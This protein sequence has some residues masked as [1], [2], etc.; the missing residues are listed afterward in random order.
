MNWKYGIVKT[1]LEDGSDWYYLAEVYGRGRHSN[2]EYL[3][4]ISGETQDC[5]VDVIQVIYEDLQENL[6]V[7]D[8]IRS[9]EDE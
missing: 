4:A 2:I 7:I 6:M 9:E 5:V 8:E 1:K 3:G